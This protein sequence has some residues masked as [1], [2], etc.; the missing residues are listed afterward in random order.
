[1]NDYLFGKIKRIAAS[2]GIVSDAW[3]KKELGK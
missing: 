1:M 3:C 2:Y